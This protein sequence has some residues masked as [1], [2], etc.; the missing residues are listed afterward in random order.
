MNPLRLLLESK[1]KILGALVSLTDPSIAEIMGNIGYD[2][3]WIDMEHT[4][5]SYKDVLC[6]L[7]ASK[8]A[9]VSAV[10]RVPQNDLTATK[11]ILEMGPD[12]IIFPMVKSAKEL[13]DLMATTLYPPVGTRG[14]GP[15]RAIGYGADDAKEYVT[16]KSLDL[17]RFVQIEH[18]DLIDEIEE[19]VKNPYVDGFIFGPNDLSLSLNDSLNV[20][21]ETTFS[22][23]QY[24]T[25]LLKKHNKIIGVAGGISEEEIEKWASIGLDMF[26]MGSDW[27]F[28]YDRGKTNLQ[29]LKKFIK[30]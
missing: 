8:S 25:K 10:V 23:I 26:Y 24:A 16:K 14:F 7:N 12:G 5:M 11:K 30:E 22:K 17:C 1:K 28:I 27:G 3:V 9:G 2:S 21:G 15:I 6:H 13:N 4:Y 20:F 29:T 18:I 19:I